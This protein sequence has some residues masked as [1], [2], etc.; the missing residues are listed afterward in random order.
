MCEHYKKK[1]TQNTQKTPYM[2]FYR[3]IKNLWMND[4]TAATHVKTTQ[5]AVAHMVRL[6]QKA[7]GW[8]M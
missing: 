7:T 2:I 5:K 8:R 1:K 3:N 4:K 6:R